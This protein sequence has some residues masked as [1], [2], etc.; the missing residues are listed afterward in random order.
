MDS[1][2][3]EVNQQ[4]ALGTKRGKHGDSKNDGGLDRKEGCGDTQDGSIGDH[5]DAVPFFPNGTEVD[6]RLARRVKWIDSMPSFY[7]SGMPSLL[8]P[9]VAH[10]SRVI[11]GLVFRLGIIPRME[12]TA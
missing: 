3:W 12:S 5:T 11:S 4:E 8:L 9:F 2:V 7:I 1:W 10:S 6:P